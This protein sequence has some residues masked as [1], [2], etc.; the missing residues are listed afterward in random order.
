MYPFSFLSGKGLVIDLQP[1]VYLTDVTFQQKRSKTRKSLLVIA[2]TWTCISLALLCVCRFCIYSDRVGTSWSMFY[3]GEG[4]W[5]RFTDLVSLLIGFQQQNAFQNVN[6]VK[7]KN[8]PVSAEC[9]HGCKMLPFSVMSLKRKYSPPFVG[10]A[11][12]SWCSTAKYISKCESS[13]VTKLIFLCM[14]WPQN[15]TTVISFKLKVPLPHCVSW[16]AAFGGA[17]DWCLS[18]TQNMQGPVLVLVLFPVSCPLSILLVGPE[19]SRTRQNK[20][21][22]N[23]AHTA[24]KWRI[25]DFVVVLLLSRP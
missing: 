12:Y 22:Q 21:N 1:K 24:L 6:Q 17:T 20:W 15:T 13:E 10:L 5:H 3:G 19:V 16:Q 9:Y 4:N 14:C 8:S 7:W 2:R 11:G 23:F 25:S 18:P